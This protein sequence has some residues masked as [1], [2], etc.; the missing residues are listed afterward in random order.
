VAG[1]KAIKSFVNHETGK[2]IGVKSRKQK[3]GW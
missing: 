1:A 2:P 3:L